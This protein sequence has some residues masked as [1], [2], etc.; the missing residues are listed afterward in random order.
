LNLRPLGYEPR[1]TR[2]TDH[3]P[4]RQS[5]SGGRIEHATVS[6]VVM[7]RG[8]LPRVSVTVVVTSARPSCAPTTP[9]CRAAA[10]S[11]SS[12]PRMRPAW[13]Q[14]TPAP[15][16]A[17]RTRSSRSH[18]VPP[19]AGCALPRRSPSATCEPD[20][21][22]ARTPSSTAS[23]SPSPAT[24]TASGSRSRGVSAAEWS[25]GRTPPP[26]HTTLPLSSRT[27]FVPITTRHSTISPAA[28]SDR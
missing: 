7:C 15:R 26:C 12:L 5:R 10:H 20:R 19:L 8:P 16:A 18:T 17:P 11:T 14:R 23:R 28:P 13:L 22:R 9:R 3:R 2:L 21:G 6:R 27:R 4:P 25:P 1:T 24:A